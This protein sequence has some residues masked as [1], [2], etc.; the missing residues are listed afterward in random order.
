MWVSWQ[1]AYVWGFIIKFNQ[2]DK[3]RGL[4]SLVEYVSPFLP[5]LDRDKLMWAL[6]SAS[7]A[8]NDASPNLWRYVLTMYLKISSFNS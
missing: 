2:R 4:E 3:I 7:L 8:L 5:F 6:M 1:V